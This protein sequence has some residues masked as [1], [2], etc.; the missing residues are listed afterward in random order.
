M[1]DAVGA[2][3]ALVITAELRGSGFASETERGGQQGEAEMGSHPP[4]KGPRRGG[5]SHD[6]HDATQVRRWL[7]RGRGTVGEEGAD[8]RARPVSGRRGKERRGG[9]FA[10]R[11]P[12]QRAR[13]RKEREGENRGRAKKRASRPTGPKGGRERKRSFLFLI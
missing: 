2:A 7:R 4:L 6:A 1:V 3:G 8:G 5:G 10:S 12:A 9:G 11:G 13:G